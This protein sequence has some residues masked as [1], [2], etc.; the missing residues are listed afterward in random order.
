MKAPQNLSPCKRT[1]RAS[2]P[3]PR[4]A[5]K[6]EIY[7]YHFQVDGRRQLDPLNT[8]TKPSYT[9]IESALLISGPDGPMPWETTAVPHGVVRRHTYTSHIVLG[10][11]ANQSEF[12]VYTPPGY[13]PHARTKYP[14]LYLLHG[15]S[16]RA[17]GWTAIGH[18]NDILDNLIAQGKAR[19]MIVVMPLG[20]G[21]MSFVR[22]ASV[23]SRAGSAAHNADLFSQALLTEV[24]PQ[25]EKLYRVSTKREDSAIAGLSMGG[26]EAL[27]VGLTHTD[28]FA[29]IGGFSAGVQQLDPAIYED[30]DPKNANLK[31]LYLDCGTEDSLIEPVRRLSAALKT[32]GFDVDS[33]E[34]AGLGHNWLVWRPDLVAFASAI[35]QQK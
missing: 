14:V 27:T 19:P 21:D 31:L 18:A 15:W 29:W 4:D 8:L 7:G 6:P 30:L 20:Y 26:Q 23:H 24:M 11:D 16:D 25:V 33:R 1:K 5:L 28:R 32:Q 10:L 2:G 12:F 34:T 13:D 22:D 3:S 9:A 17:D 35:F